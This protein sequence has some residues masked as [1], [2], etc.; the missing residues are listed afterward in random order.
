MDHSDGKQVVDTDEITTQKLSERQKQKLKSKQNLVFISRSEFEAVIWVQIGEPGK[1]KPNMVGV[2]MESNM[3][4]FARKTRK[5]ESNIFTRP[6]SDHR[7]P[8]SLVSD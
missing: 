1:W 5:Q 4:K 8:L 2:G 3:A 7:L 6:G